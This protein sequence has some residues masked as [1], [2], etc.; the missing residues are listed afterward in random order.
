MLSSVIEMFPNY[1]RD[2]LEKTRVISQAIDTGIARPVKQRHWSV[3]PAIEK[4]MFSEIYRM[5]NLD[6]IEES[7]SP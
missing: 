2:A 3:S 5:L 4:I 6:I 7:T 1:E